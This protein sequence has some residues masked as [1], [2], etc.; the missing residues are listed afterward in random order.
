M[1][2]LDF[3]SSVDISTTNIVSLQRLPDDLVPPIKWGNLFAHDGKLHMF[4]GEPEYSSIIKEDWTMPSPEDTPPRP[5]INDT[6]FTYDI[7]NKKWSTKPSGLGDQNPG[8]TNFAYSAKNG[9]GWVYSGVYAAGGYHVNKTLVEGLKVRENLKSVIKFDLPKLSLD[10]EVVPINPV[11]L[12]ESGTMSYLPS[13]GKEGILVV[14]GGRT[15]SHVMVRSG[16]K[17]LNQIDIFHINSI[18]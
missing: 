5:T 8:S 10:E 17:I 9:I 1:R 7:Q 6:L 15:E 14:L 12:V 3:T 4:G 18:F 2:V 13:V 11:G 16:H